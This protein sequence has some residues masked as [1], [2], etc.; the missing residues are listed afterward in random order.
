MYLVIKKALSKELTEFCYDYYCTK[1]KV[2]RFFLDT[3]CFSFGDF[4]LGSIVLEKI[5]EILG[6]GG[7]RDSQI[8]NTYSNYGDVVIETLLLKL[9][10]LVEAETGMKLSPTYTYARI[11]KK[12][13]ELKRHKDRFSCE[14]STTMNL[15]GDLWDIYLEPSGKEGKQGISILLES[16]DL[17]IYKGCELEHW[18]ETFEGNSCGQA[19][20]HY[21]D[22]S[23][24]NSEENRYDKRPFLGLPYFFRDDS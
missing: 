17:L 8:P 5:L 11:Y 10:P 22:L 14:I 24:N 23:S 18:R 12:G 13:D 20:L 2:A 16:G 3:K 6:W 7:W 15:G 9:Q 21:N 1:M 19:F 4:Y